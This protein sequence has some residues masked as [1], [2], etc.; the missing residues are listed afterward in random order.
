MLFV[1]L[2]LVVLM[3]VIVVIVVVVVVCVRMF[4]FLCVC[5]VLGCDCVFACDVLLNVACVMFVCMV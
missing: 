1:V 2:C 5:F 3:C 4:G